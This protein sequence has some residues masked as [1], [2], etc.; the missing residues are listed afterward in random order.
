MAF[1]QDEIQSI[2]S[3]V[4]SS[5]QTNARTIDQ[6]TPVT[7]LSDND[8]FEINGGKK[9]TYA[10]LNSLITELMMT[11]EEVST[12]FA[13]LIAQKS[14]KPN[15][16]APL[17]ANSQLP[18]KHL[19]TQALGV[20]DF[21]GI[22]SGI[23]TSGTVTD[24]G[25]KSPNSVVVYNSDTNRFVLQ[26]GNGS[27]AV[28][29]SSWSNTALHGRPDTNGSIIPLSNKLY[30]YPTGGGL[31]YIWNGSKLQQDRKSVV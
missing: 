23:T 30:I 13:T 2:V 9:V 6:L 17:D 21:G 29:Y 26:V 19:P 1:T 8:C 27:G 4:L 18:W 22:V 5:L 25:Y 12:L 31:A 11:E 16:V 14:G 20:M 10:V 28:Y 7:S 3:A 24:K 15:G